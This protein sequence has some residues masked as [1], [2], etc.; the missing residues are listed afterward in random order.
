LQSEP[1]QFLLVR[2]QDVV[3][4]GRHDLMLKTVKC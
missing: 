2:T 1:R 3:A 4:L